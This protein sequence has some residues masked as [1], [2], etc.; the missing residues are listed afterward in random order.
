MTLTASEVRATLQAAGVTL[1]LREGGPVAR[2]ASALTPALR[3]L[4]AAHRQDLLALLDWEA[5]ADAQAER[6]YHDDPFA[7][8]AGHTCLRTTALIRAP[9]WLGCGPYLAF[10]PEKLP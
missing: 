10:D 8:A 7:H 3:G 5:R 6:A 2:P 4:L 1:S 9:D